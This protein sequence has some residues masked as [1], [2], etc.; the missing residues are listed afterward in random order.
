MPAS[1]RSE[2]AAADFQDLRRVGETAFI[3][4]LEHSKTQ[5]A[6]PSASATPD[7]PVLGRAGA[8]LDAWLRAANISEGPLFRRLWGERVGPALSPKSATLLP[9]S[10]LVTKLSS[11]AI[12][13]VPVMVAGTANA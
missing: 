7:K 5:Q 3:Y 12:V 6:G 8:A 13:P 2:I 9:D 11:S 4:R 1:V 10:S